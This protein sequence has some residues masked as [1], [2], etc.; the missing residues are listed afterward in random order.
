MKEEFTV[1]CT[2]RDIDG[3]QI[4]CRIT[5]TKW[6]QDNFCTCTIYDSKGRK[7]YN[8]FA[9]EQKY[10]Y[11]AKLHEQNQ[12]QVSYLRQLNEYEIRISFDNACT[13]EDVTIDCQCSIP[14]L[15][16]QKRELEND[17]KQII[18]L[19]EQLNNKFKFEQTKYPL[20]NNNNNNNN[21]N[22]D[23]VY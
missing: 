15:L 4:Q 13:T 18:D 5:I 22:N 3:T 20:D 21:N 7:Y 19:I 12:L 11:Y 6:E 23:N 17:L 16:A 14:Y 2:A 10:F 1:L 9:L 8:N